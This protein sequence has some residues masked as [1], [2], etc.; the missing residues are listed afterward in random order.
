MSRKTGIA[1]GLLAVGALLSSPAHPSFDQF[2]L[3][4]PE[5]P[6]P[7]ASHF[8]IPNS[9]ENNLFDRV[10][11]WQGTLPKGVFGDGD[12]S[13]SPWHDGSPRMM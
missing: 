8:N 5:T 10:I 11:D 7:Y 4:L 6:S 2:D 1:V 9:T 13:I 3:A 12:T